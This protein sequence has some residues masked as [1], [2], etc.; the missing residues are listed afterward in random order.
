MNKKFNTQIF[1]DKSKEIHGD[2]YNYSQVDYKNCDT[3]VKIKCPEHG[4]FEQIPYLH[5]KKGSGCIK[6][7]EKK[8]GASFRKNNENFIQEAKNIHNNFYDYSKT[9]Y[10]KAQKVVKII[11]PEHGVFTQTPTNHL[12][13]KGCKKCYNNKV[14][15]RLLLSTEEFI[16]RAELVHD[17][18]FDYSNVVYE[19]GRVKVKIK[20]PEHGIFEQTPENHLSNRGCKKCRSSKGEK[21]IRKI[22]KE[23]SIKFKEQHTFEL[24]R[25]INKLPFDFYLPEY[26]LCIEFDGRQHFEVIDFYGGQKG[27]DSTKRND[28]I[29]N[30]YCKNN[31][32]K[33]FRIKYDS[34]IKNELNKIIF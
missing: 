33:L 20:C 29:K 27:F 25:H 3:K 34:I 30:D 31:G 15:D 5:Y 1:I 13:G 19:G 8:V 28:Q 32:V 16:L 14:R 26:N 22:L 9:K 10:E 23:N 7:A 21:E 2:K 12:S 4:I 11:C 6:C 24:C 18:K 17:Y